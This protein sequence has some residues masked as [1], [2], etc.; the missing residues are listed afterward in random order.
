MRRR[1]RWS[2]AA[3]VAALVLGLSAAARAT[4]P[5]ALLYGQVLRGPTRPVC[6]AGVPCDAP[7]PGVTLVFR[8][9]ALE[10]GRATTGRDG[11]YRIALPAGRYAVGSTRK[12]LGG[13]VSP[14]VV[15]LL[16]GQRRRLVFRVDTGIR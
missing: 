9:G 8:R 12:F 5:Q 15:V 3:L 14:A 7:A 6:E 1:N 10:V 13:S 16:P 2:A 11:V 4:T